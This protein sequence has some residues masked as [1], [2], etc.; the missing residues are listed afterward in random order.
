MQPPKAPTL[1][2]Y[3]LTLGD[4]WLLLSQ[5]GGV[6]AICRRV[7]SSGRFNID[8][9]HGKQRGKRWKD[10]PPAERK[11][12][13]RGILCWAC[14]VMIVGRGVTAPKLRAAAAYLEA[15]RARD[16]AAK[17]AA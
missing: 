12:T 3:G 2:K 14:N 16:Q 1:A 8:H 13:V 17:E 5:Q 9:Q 7:P 6:C 10:L 11:A 4:W 15:W